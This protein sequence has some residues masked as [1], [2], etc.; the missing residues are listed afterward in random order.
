MKTTI[1]L[2]FILISSVTSSLFSQV[3]SS[4]EYLKA[5]NHLWNICYDLNY[6]KNAEDVQKERS[7][8]LPVLKKNIESAKK[9]Y[10]L[11]NTKSPADKDVKQLGLW[12]KTIEKSYEN[13]SSE[14]WESNP[15]WQMGF[16]LIEMDL[17][18]FVNEKL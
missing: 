12:I 1:T 17:R 8:I 5:T 6:L 15:I 10:T 18:D 9:D 11:L 13:L 16:T 7:S 2:L 3:S 4:K 14:S